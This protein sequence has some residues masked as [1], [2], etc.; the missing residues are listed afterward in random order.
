MENGEET[1]TIGK[2]EY[3]ELKHNTDILSA[4][5]A[6]GV[7]NWGGYD[8]AME[9]LDNNKGLRCENEQMIKDSYIIGKDIK[10]NNNIPI[11]KISDGNDILL[12]DIFS[13]IMRLKVFF[14]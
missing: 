9:I 4:L 8:Y 14:Y 13:S 11:E 7:D 2:K 1:I 12:S 6:A 10:L 5:N 3:N